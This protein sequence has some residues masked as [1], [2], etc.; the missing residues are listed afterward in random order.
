[1]SSLETKA[2][3]RK[4]SSLASCQDKANSAE[5]RVSSDHKLRFS[6][7]S[8]TP[9]TRLLEIV[10]LYLNPRAPTPV[11]EVAEDEVVDIAESTVNEEEPASVTGVPPVTSASLNFTTASEIDQQADPAL[12]DSAEWDRVDGSSLEEAPADV[13]LGESLVDVSLDGHGAI[14]DSGAA[15]SH[16]EAS[17]VLADVSRSLTAG[18][19]VA[20]SRQWSP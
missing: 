12:A 9:D 2:R 16:T 3:K 10:D 20:Y 19:F 17:I 4:H 18:L 15:S 7:L 11:P 1:M 13:E 5:C 8:F 6:K 14:Q